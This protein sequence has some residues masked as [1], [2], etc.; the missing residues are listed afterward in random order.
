MA[1]LLGASALFK[2]G[3][4]AHAIP[5]PHAHRRAPMGQAAHDAVTHVRLKRARRR[6]SRP[7]PG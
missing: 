1:L 3:G 2:P 4:L 5:H 6:R 7:A